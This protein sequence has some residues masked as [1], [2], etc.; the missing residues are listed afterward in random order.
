MLVDGAA[1]V[2]GLFVGAV[3][4]RLWLGY[5][6]TPPPLSLVAMTAMWIVAI[7]LAGGY[8]KRFIGHGSLESRRIFLAMLMLAAGIAFTSWLTQI[9]VARSFL[10]V[11]LPV[12]AVGASL[13]RRQLQRIT[14]PHA[15]RQ[16]LSQRTLL[17][18][19]P[20]SVQRISTILR[21]SEKH[22]YQL[23]GACILGGPPPPDACRVRYLGDFES[24]LVVVRAHRVDAVLV[25]ADSG[26]TAAA[27]RHLAWDLEGTGASVVVAPG[28][29][30]VSGARV[31]VRPVNGLPLLYVDQPCFRGLRH[32]AKEVGEPLLAALGLV[33]LAPLLAV[34]A[35][36]IKLDTP[37]PVF[38]RQWRIGR[39]GKSFP[40]MKFRTMVADAEDHKAELMGMS[41]PDRPLFKIEHDPRITRVGSWLR[42][43][44]LDELPQ[45]IN[46]VRGQMSLVGPRPHLIEELAQFGP[47]SSRR[48]L[49][50]PGMT[51]IWQ[52]NGRSDL[53]H[54][55][56]M[57]L[58]L[59]Y[60]DN[61][62]LGLDASI[63]LRTLAVMVDKSGA[64]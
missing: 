1:S 51:G 30:E 52:V 35:L 48:L 18:G 33:V 61:W 20:E 3:A 21:R 16:L 55:E 6:A 46:V 23:I 37:G 38:F 40:I 22:P 5:P 24:V 42:R 8:Q 12:S 31:A 27:V 60:V 44:S 19:E 62:S 39:D 64:Y 14:R 28:V 49:V 59:S 56:A 26:L 50:K 58:D 15:G 4:S 34:V 43:T 29:C 47:D 9:D 45:L 54:D 41:Q 25:A 53:P 11:S 7:D 63:I 57:R 17:V 36:L 32:R 2:F 10:L 13:G